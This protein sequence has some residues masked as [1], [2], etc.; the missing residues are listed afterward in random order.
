MNTTTRSS[1]LGAAIPLALALLAFGCSRSA[2]GTFADP[3]DAAK[4]MHELI[5]THDVAKIE[6]VFGAG[7]ADMF[8]SGDA[9]ADQADLARVKQLIEEKVSFED[10][11]DKT[12][13]ILLGKGDWPFPV[14]LVKDGDGWRFDS[15]EGREEI[16]NRFIGRN[17]LLTLATLRAI[18]DAQREYAAVG[19]DGRPPQYAGRFRSSEGKQDGLYW[20]TADGEPESPLGDLVAAA[21]A[22]GYSAEG[23]ER[24][25][26]N[27]Y[28]FRMLEAQGRSAP[29]GARS[30]V[31][32]SGNLTGGFACIAWPAKHG[33]SGVMT[34][35]VSDRGL[36]FEKDLGDAT[37]AAA[38]A[39]TTYDPDDTWAPT[40]D[41][42]DVPETIA[43]EAP[44]AGGRKN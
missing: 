29:G 43:T 28:F 1:I 15:A 27:G 31:D 13:I 19:H 8:D 21:S 22:K 9:V 34:F 39:I 20:P 11:D 18:V 30:Y 2:P 5:G 25:P 40:W 35:L 42:D 14:P 24:M 7:N 3:A 44:A 23:E 4:A 32:A 37:E 41:P 38:D 17:E 6:A 10:L 16:A 26:F 12:K 36:V 33:V